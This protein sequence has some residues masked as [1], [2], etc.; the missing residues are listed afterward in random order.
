MADTAVAGDP[1]PR[2]TTTVKR[3]LYRAVSCAEIT[4][5]VIKDKQKATL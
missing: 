1:V 5:I 3:L 2:G 4:D